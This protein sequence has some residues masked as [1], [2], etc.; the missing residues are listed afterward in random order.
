MVAVEA[1]GAGLPVVATA[2]AGPREILQ[3]DTF[4]K[5]VPIGDTRSM[6]HAIDAALAD[7]GDPT[8]RIARARLF[9]SEAGF[10]A[11]Q[12]LLDEIVR[13]HRGG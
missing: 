5:I 10:A 12:A 1:L 3:G 13:E 2:C 8:P 9:S 6:A 4:G 11:W 7:P